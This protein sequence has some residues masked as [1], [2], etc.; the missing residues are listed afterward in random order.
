MLKTISS[1]LLVTARRSHILWNAA[2]SL[3]QSHI[4]QKVDHSTYL[5]SGTQTVVDGA[6]Y[7][8]EPATVC[9]HWS[10]SSGVYVCDF[11]PQMI[12]LLNLFGYATSGFITAMGTDLTTNTNLGARLLSSSTSSI[13][14]YW[15]Q[16]RWGEEKKGDWM[17]EWREEGKGKGEWIR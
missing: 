3:Y 7:D 11:I 9:R 5:H 2:H 15:I 8:N 6:T 12:F 4:V 16:M 14:S 10:D 13:W 17:G 1:L